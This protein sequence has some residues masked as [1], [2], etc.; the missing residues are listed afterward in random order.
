MVR[1]CMSVEYLSRVRR[2]VAVAIRA[3]GRKRCDIA[4]GVQQP[5]QHLPHDR[6]IVNHQDS[7]FTHF[8]V[9]NDSGGSRL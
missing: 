9:Q 4:S 3:I 7:S 8:V 6:L 2:D 1:S 5:L